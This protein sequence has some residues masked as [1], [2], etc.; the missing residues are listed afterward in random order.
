MAMTLEELKEKII[1]YCDEEM[2]CELLYITTTELVDAF[3]DRLIRN[4]DRLAGDFEDEIE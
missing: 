3:E 1:M 2:I 4:F